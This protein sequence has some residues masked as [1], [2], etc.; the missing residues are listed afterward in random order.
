MDRTPLPA[1][2]AGAEIVRAANPWTRAGPSD[3]HERLIRNVKG[4]VCGRQAGWSGDTLTHTF[5][6]AASVLNK[7]TPEKFDRLMEQ[8]L[9]R[10]QPGRARGE[11][12][13]PL[14]R[15]PGAGHHHC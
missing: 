1:G 5:H 12:R 4:C 6:A 2:E 11:Q 14:T 9:V 13:S 7:I 15:R 10:C 8:L 3:E